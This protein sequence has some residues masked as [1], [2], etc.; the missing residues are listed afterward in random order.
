MSSMCIVQIH[1]TD[2]NR[3]ILSVAM[4]VMYVLLSHTSLSIIEKLVSIH[5]NAKVHPI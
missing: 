3:K 4:G 5:G 2:N 1:V